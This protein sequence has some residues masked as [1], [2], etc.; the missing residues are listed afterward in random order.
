MSWEQ[1]LFGSMRGGKTIFLAGDQVFGCRIARSRRRAAGEFA[2]V[3][4]TRCLCI[5]ALFVSGCSLE[6]ALSQSQQTVSVARA[7]MQQA[8]EIFNNPHADRESQIVHKPWVTGKPISLAADVT[9]PEA[10]RTQVRTTLI[11]KDSKATLAQVASRIA[12]ASSIPVRVMPDALLP[13]HHFMPRLHGV[14]GVAQQTHL[15]QRPMPNGTFPLAKVLDIVAA[16]HD[17]QWRYTNRGIEIYR[18]Q[19]RVFDVRA[20]TLS[21]GS[22][23]KL[24]RAG[25]SGSEGFQS[26]SQ[27]TLTLASEPVLQA[28]KHRIEPFL[29]LAGVVSA[30]P[31]SLTSIV[32]TDT[33]AA[34]D[35]IAGYL[36]SVNRSM[37]LRVRLVFEEM[38][39]TRKQGQEQ[40][41]DWSLAFARGLVAIGAGSRP[42]GSADPVVQVGAS[43]GALSASLTVRALSDY[44]NVLRH[45]AVPV[46]TLNRRPVT[47]AVRSTF[48]YV[49]QVKALATSSNKDGSASNQP[50][51]AISQKRETTGAFLTLVPDVQEDG[52]ILLSVAYDNTVAMPLTSLH[53]GS[54]SNT[55]QVQQLTVHGSGTVQ[56]VALRAGSPVLIAGFEEREEQNE[57]S[58]L[59]PTMPRAAGG[60]DKVSQQQRM[61]LIF[62]TAQIEEGL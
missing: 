10:L 19:T 53:F 56:Q 49:D 15:A 5:V 30:Q 60:F 6:P 39:V 7:Q 22:E 25:S 52:Q 27:T 59:G 13:P 54:E 18:T 1:I 61:T 38:T 29:T 4:M 32:V 24:G 20:L 62:V 12:L 34:L 48:T 16:E 11:F 14:G 35:G 46:V 45:T 33:P 58:R 23:M 28:I 8:R 55:Y 26:S 21:A 51:V 43:A 17:V 2:S 44:A 3:T 50:G 41:V 57:G 37:S 47:H 9:M 31:G 40:G 42:G 36:E